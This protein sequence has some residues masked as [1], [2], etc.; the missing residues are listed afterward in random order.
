VAREELGLPPTGRLYAAISDEL[1]MVATFPQL[2]YP[3]SWPDHVHVTGPMLFELP[4]PEG[5]LPE[6]DG[7]LVLVAGSTAQDQE[8]EVVRTSLEALAEEP[9][10]VLA[11]LNQRGLE[12]PGP[13]PHNATVVDWVSYSQVIPHASIV[14]C[15]GGH[16]TVARSLAEG[17]PLVIRPAGADMGENGA[18]VTW[19]GVGLMLPRGVFGRHS[20][21][22][23]VRKVLAEE[24]FATR[25]RALARWSRRNDGAEHGAE[26]VDGHLGR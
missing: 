16:G 7:P 20:L 2:E 1:A 8:L 10:R 5:D 12:W 14:A 26:L 9:V 23:A 19:A 13:V 24:G 25:A 6:G 15:N 17:V 4:H 3:R 21:R 18:R 22:A 11:T